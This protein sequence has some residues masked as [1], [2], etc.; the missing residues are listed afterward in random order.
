L[1]IVL[2]PGSESKHHPLGWGHSWKL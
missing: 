1:P 2:R